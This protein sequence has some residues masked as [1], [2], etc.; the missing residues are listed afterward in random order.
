MRDGGHGERRVGRVARATGAVLCRVIGLDRVRE[1]PGD[2][3][4]VLRVWLLLGCRRRTEPAWG[5]NGAL[6][7]SGYTRQTTLAWGWD[8]H[9]C[10]A[11]MAK[12]G[13]GGRSRWTGRGGEWTGAPLTSAH[14]PD[15]RTR[16][17]HSGR[18][19]SARRPLPA[20][21][22]GSARPPRP[23]TRCRPPIS[24]RAQRGRV[25]SC[26]SARVKP[27]VTM[28]RIP[29]QLSRLLARPPAL[30]SLPSHPSALRS[31]VAT[32][33][34][35]TLPSLL[36]RNHLLDTLQPVPSLTAS[37]PIL[38]VVQQVRYRTYGAEYQPSQRKRKRKHGFL[39]RKKS[40]TGR[41]ILARRLAKGR[42]SLTH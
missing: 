12:R 41:K 16:S 18:G 5:R 40:L 33:L 32:A 30:P 31:I 21:R 28:P 42:R 4:V 35:R 14:L 2:V 39:A 13:N 6:P 1:C 29:F 25:G 11:R 10:A 38:Q 23:Q 27:T 20:A 22:V 15:Q 3:F 34:P 19:H 9:C 24:R 17:P 37:S 26:V 7:G 36:G 8:R